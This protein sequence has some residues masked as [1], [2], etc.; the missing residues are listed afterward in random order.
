MT[1]QLVTIYRPDGSSETLRADLARNRVHFAPDEWSLTKPAPLG[2]QYEKPRYL[3]TRDLK[4]AE[5]SRFLHEPPF[6]ETA[7][8]T[9]QYGERF[10]AAGEEIET[11]AWPHAS[12]QGLNFSGKQVVAFFKAEMKSRLPQS[13][14]HQGRVRL[15]DGISGSL[16]NVV[17]TPRPE[18]MNLR[19]V[20]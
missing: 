15:T 10:L 13:P 7:S 8:D 18:P 4:P 16:P 19:P 20:A 2:W 1:E 17:Q 5:K 3:V 12:M 9:Y 11:T 6:A 14:W